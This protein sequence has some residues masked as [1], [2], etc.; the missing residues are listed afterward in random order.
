MRHRPDLTRRPL[1]LL[2]VVVL[3]TVVGTAGCTAKP[4]ATSADPNAPVTLKL[5]AFGDTSIVQKQAEQYHALHPNVTVDVTTVA[6]AEDARTA[7]L[8]KLAAGN[9]L[10]DV[11]QLEISWVGQLQKYS[12]KFQTL[13][14][15]QF[16]PFLPVQT[17]PVA[18]KDGGTFAYGF[19][20]GPQA[21]CY[22][23]DMFKKAGLPTDPAAVATLL[24]TTWDDYFAAGRKYA[25]GGG[26]AKWYDSSYLIYNAQIEQMEFPYESADGAVV[27]NNP[28]VEKAF[29]DTLAAGSQLSAKLSAFS[30]DWNSGMGTSKYATLACPSWLLST[31]QGN[32]KGVT[33]WRIANAFPGGGGSVGGSFLAVPTQSANPTQAEA[34][35][36]WLSAPDQ[37]IATFEGGGAFPSRSQALDDPK[38][39]AVTNPYFGD[40][41]VGTIFSDRSKAIPKVMYKG[42]H[43]IGID[44]AAFNAITRVEA[45][46]QS[47]DEAWQQFVTEA[48]AAK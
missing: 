13:P 12:N 45:G 27:A 37:Q 32:S 3:A 15:D 5:G 36:S 40:A 29:K 30:E 23:A 1:R 8:T 26:P 9:G 16:G 42:P 38:L 7:L 18:T 6:S 17:Q 33:D 21:I 46:Q 35:A 2:A 11:E 48:Q 4:A 34:L 28:Q 43:Y 47:V 31:I 41:K 25:A 24:G 10:N 44:T 20:T 14:P 39:A 19:G 22:H